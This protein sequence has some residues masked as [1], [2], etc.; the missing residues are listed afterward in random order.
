MR[1]ED[2]GSEAEIGYC[3]ECDVL[4]EGRINRTPVELAAE[5]LLK[6]CEYTI[7]KLRLVKG[8]T[9]NIL[10][11]IAAIEKAKAQDNQSNQKN[12]S[13]QDEHKSSQ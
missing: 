1:C 11:I 12:P 10:P 7:D 2:C 3:F 9:F 6:A 4:R 13:A 8:K 5:D